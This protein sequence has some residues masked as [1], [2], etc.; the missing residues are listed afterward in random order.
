MTSATN[1]TGDGGGSSSSSSSGG[2]LTAGGGGATSNSTS[3]SVSNGDTAVISIGNIAE[4]D[5]VMSLEG[6]DNPFNV[7]KG[8]TASIK[9]PGKE[10][11]KFR[12]KSSE[13]KDLLVNG[14]KDWYDVKGA[15]M[16]ASLV[17]H[18]EGKNDLCQRLIG[19][20]RM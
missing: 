3:T 10:D 4:T 6:N 15:E 18:N 5:A 12:A 20:Q 8:A 2:A 17:I 14:A 16:P 13:G 19:T 7:P 11:Y 1:S 9:L